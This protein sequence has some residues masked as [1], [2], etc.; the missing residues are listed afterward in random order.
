LP[1]HDELAWVR[2]PCHAPTAP[3]WAR[4]ASARPRCVDRTIQAEADRRDL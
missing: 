4:A 2:I 1:G 3:T